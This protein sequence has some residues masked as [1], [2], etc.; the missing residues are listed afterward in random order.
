[1]IEITRAK[2]PYGDYVC[3]NDVHGSTPDGRRYLIARAGQKIPLHQAT[4]LGLVGQSKPVGPSSVK[5]ADIEATDS[6]KEL[7]NENGIDLAT[8]NGSG[9]N[10]RIIKSDVEALVNN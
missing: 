3:E 9:A 6:A 5:G 4:E 7:A 10:G 1:M 2:K 8:V